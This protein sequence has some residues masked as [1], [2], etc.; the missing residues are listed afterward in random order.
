MQHIKV[1]SDEEVWSL[2]RKELPKSNCLKTQT[3]AAIVKEMEIRSIGTN[4]CAPEGHKYGD[5][6]EFCP[7]MSITTGEHYELCS[8]VHAEVMACLNIREGRTSNEIGKYASHLNPPKELIM[9]A[10]TP[11]EK[12]QLNGSYLYLLGHYWVCNNCKFFL[13]VVGIPESHIKLNKIS[14]DAVKNKYQI[15]GVFAE[16][17]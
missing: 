17:H 4:S 16:K 3:A 10:F 7:R 6:L 2:L 11:Q 12:E 8:P 13:G 1:A 15:N 5:K 14:A 9:S